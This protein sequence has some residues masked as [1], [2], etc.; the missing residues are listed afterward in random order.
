MLILSN[1][2]I[3][4]MK[5]KLKTPKEFDFN[6]TSGHYHF[7]YDLVKQELG[8]RKIYDVIN[9]YVFYKKPK[10]ELSYK[11]QI[12]RNASGMNEVYCK[13]MFKIIKN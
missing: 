9:H 8:L 12:I 13:S 2:K 10:I 6:K 1:I 3:K 7:T 11:G 5:V 4:Y